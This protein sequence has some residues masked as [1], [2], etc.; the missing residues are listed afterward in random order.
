MIL[1]KVI[2]MLTV[3]AP[4]DCL[5]I[6]TP[7]CT[8]T[9]VRFLK[10]KD[11]R[12]WRKL[13]RSSRSLYQYQSLNHLPHRR[14]TILSKTLISLIW[15]TLVSLQLS[16]IRH[17][18]ERLQS[19]LESW[20]TNLIRSECRLRQEARFVDRFKLSKTC[21]SWYKIRKGKKNFLSRIPLL[22]L[23]QNKS[24]R[25]KKGVQKIKWSGFANYFKTTD[26]Q[27]YQKNSTSNWNNHHIMTQ[28]DSNF[29][30]KILL[31]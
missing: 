26:S 24:K 4:I 13:N 11:R 27:K 9:S 5:K 14:D 8:T 30:V 17:D 20:P 22:R 31:S 2:L 3:S 23:L 18:R 28:K 7:T 16:I 21:T 29:T 25:K 15:S 10:T 6:M 19:K 12:C 1:L